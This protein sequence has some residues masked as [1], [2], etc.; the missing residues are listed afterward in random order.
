MN[1][2]NSFANGLFAPLAADYERWARVLGLGQ[3]GRW[4]RSMVAG[5]AVVA[6]SRVLD[7]A[8][9]TGLISR[10]LEDSD[11]RVTA[12]DQSRE[13]L[14]RHRGRQR[15]L[16]QAEHLPF[17]S[18]TFDALTFGYLLRYVAD[19]VACMAELTRVVKRGGRVGM[20]EFGV[21]A[22][23][24]R[25]LWRI[26]TRGLL[27]IIG[28]LIGTGWATVGAFLG[29]SIEQFHRT[30]PLPVLVSVWESAGLVD[31][32]VARPSLGAGLVMWGRKE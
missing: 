31:V 9:G 12:L 14:T 1:S 20:V 22:P 16:A 4:R 28:R 17:P 26:Y 32:M 27:P 15:V 3:D 10:R 24:L 30:L 5:L 7:V 18:G 29:P 19:P 21:P 8:A 6:G 11:Y 23:W 25:V 13:M 2:P